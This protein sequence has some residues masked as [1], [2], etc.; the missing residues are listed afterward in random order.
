MVSLELWG[1]VGLVI[2]QQIVTES[3]AE[4]SPSHLK[5]RDASTQNRLTSSMMPSLF[6][7]DE[8][9]KG[10]GDFRFI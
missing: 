4:P 9:R 3:A 7:S 1:A 8:L 6:A 5:F 2:T 10:R